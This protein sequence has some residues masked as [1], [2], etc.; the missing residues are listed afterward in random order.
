MYELPWDRTGQT[1]IQ[2]LIDLLSVKY[3]AFGRHR[4]H[5][6]VSICW[7]WLFYAY[8]C[9]CVNAPLQWR[10]SGRT[11]ICSFLDICWSKQM[12]QEP[13]RK[14][15]ALRYIHT[16]PNDIWLYVETFR[17]SKHKHTKRSSGSVE[18]QHLSHCHHLKT[19]DSERGTSQN[20][21][22]EIGI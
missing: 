12:Q 5:F 13:S 22:C 9:N 18:S 3:K 4:S 16:Q 17:F 15:R 6:H 19:H 14:L 10:T 8:L 21:S 11:D 7:K 2:H 20:I 1:D